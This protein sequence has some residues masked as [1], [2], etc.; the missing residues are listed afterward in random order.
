MDEGGLSNRSARGAVQSRSFVAAPLVE[1]LAQP[2]ATYEAVSQKVQG[3]YVDLCKL[4]DGSIAELYFLSPLPNPSSSSSY[5]SV[6]SSIANNVT[7]LQLC[8]AFHIIKEG[9]R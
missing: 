5:F 6:Q 4:L 3:T 2:L 8:I 7:A 9:L 1:K